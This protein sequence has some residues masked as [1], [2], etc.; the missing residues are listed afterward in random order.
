MLPSRE[1]AGS[2][3]CLAYSSFSLGSHVLP[4]KHCLLF[5]CAHESLSGPLCPV[6]CLASAVPSKDVLGNQTVSALPLMFSGTSAHWLWRHRTVS[7]SSWFLSHS[8]FLR[9]EERGRGLPRAL[10]CSWVQSWE[11]K[12]W[13]NTDDAQDPGMAHHGQG[14]L[15]EKSRDTSHPLHR[16]MG[17]CTGRRDNLEVIS[18]LEKREEPNRLPA[19]HSPPCGWLPQF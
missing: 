16:K 4:S 19:P 6:S 5:V 17:F 10:L 1:P 2:G 3:L 13:A 8:L 12:Q 7:C 9:T 15:P 14:H 18:D 11:A